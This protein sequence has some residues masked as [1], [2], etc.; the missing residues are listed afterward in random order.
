MVYLNVEI[1]SFVT[2]RVRGWSCGNKP[3]IYTPEPA[4]SMP[5]AYSA[6]LLWRAVW[7]HLVRDLSLAE[8]SDLLFMSERSVRR[9]IELYHSTGDVECKKQAGPTCLLNDFEQIT[10]MQSLIAKPS[11]YLDEVQEHLFNATGTWVSLST[12]CRTVQRLGF[13]RKSLLKLPCNKVMNYAQ[14]RSKRSAGPALAG[15][16]FTLT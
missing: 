8:I 10:V 13:T 12:I 2:F 5:K 15:P 14:G 11:I 9:Y 1:T 6:D 3:G 16:V 7:L 4:F